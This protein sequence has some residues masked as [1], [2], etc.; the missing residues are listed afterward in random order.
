MSRHPH[1]RQSLWRIFRWP[2]FTGFSSIVGLVLAL[3][4][5]GWW[6]ALSWIML[7]VPIAVVVW[8]CKRRLAIP[9]SND[10][11]PGP[12]SAIQTCVASERIA[13]KNGK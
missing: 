12:D 4:G 3:V 7:L 2:L 13:C 10:R 8:F 9:A 1:K 5:D 11:S 6:D